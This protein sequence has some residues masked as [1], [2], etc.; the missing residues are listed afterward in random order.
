MENHLKDVVYHKSTAANLTIVCSNAI[1]SAVKQYNNPRYKLVCHVLLG[2]LKGQGIQ[3]ASRCIWN[4]KTD[5]FVSVTYKNQSLYVV[6]NVYG[7]Y[8]D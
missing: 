2:E 8:Q 4:E 5:N 1:K 3:T 6:A 7:V